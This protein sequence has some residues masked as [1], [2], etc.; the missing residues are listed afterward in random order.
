MKEEL[1]IVVIIPTQR[2]HPIQYA[3]QHG[4]DGLNLLGQNRVDLYLLL[5]GTQKLT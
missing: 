1:E 4:P 5:F 2:N 3:I